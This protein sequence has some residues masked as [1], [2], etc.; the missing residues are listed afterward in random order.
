M[1]GIFS[2]PKPAPRVFLFTVCC[3]NNTLFSSFNGNNAWMLLNEGDVFT[4]FKVCL[5]QSVEHE[6]KTNYYYITLI[7]NH[8]QLS[9]NYLHFC[10]YGVVA[11]EL[12][13]F[14]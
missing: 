14:R 9:Y 4:P 12:N 11:K 5:K 10:F 13:K 6:Q 1:V 2:F 8:C 3:N 7:M